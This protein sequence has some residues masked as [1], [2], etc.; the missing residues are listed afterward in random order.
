MKR[1]IGF[2]V[3]LLGT[4]GLLG[5]ATAVPYAWITGDEIKT[6]SAEVLQ[7][8]D[9]PLSFIDKKLD[10]AEGVIDKTLNGLTQVNSV[11][12]K[13]GDENLPEADAK[14][15]AE[16]AD[17]LHEYLKSAQGLVR[18]GA[19][20]ASALAKSKALLDGL[21]F[22]NQFEIS[23]EQ[24][25]QA[26]DDLDGLSTFLDDLER[27]INTVRTD[28]KASK[29]FRAAISDLSTR[30]DTKLT[31]VKGQID[32]FDRQI[33][34]AGQKVDELQEKLPGWIDI[35]RIA[36]IV[37]LVWFGL[38]QLSLLIHGWSMLRGKKSPQSPEH[39][40]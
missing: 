18:L 28:K 16:I 38:G 34:Q 23:T 12:A 5:S 31:T 11:L 22:A 4:V 32:N 14:K 24:V 7:S 26:A 29:E 10:E 36:V 25:Q 17:E 40:N 20:G 13:I 39:A 6:R 21:P 27:E 15:L 1:L 3:L 37:F 19:T 30:I 33:T 2:L 8:I 9:E 35:G